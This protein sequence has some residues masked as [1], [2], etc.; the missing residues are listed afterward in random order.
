VG[1]PTLHRLLGWA[2]CLGLLILGACRPAEL[3]PSRAELL[4]A[5]TWLMTGLETDPGF[6]INGVVVSDLFAA[7]PNCDRDD[8]FTYRPDGS[9]RVHE[10]PTKC[11]P[12]LPDKEELGTW[13][14]NADQTVLRTQPQRG[15]PTDYRVLEITP[16]RLKMSYTLSGPNYRYEL[17]VSFAPQS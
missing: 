13:Y 10:G 7:R 11:L 1:N 5:H 6:L 8:G 3:A 17:T 2:A 15:S 9:Y 14:F 16:Q 12:Q 4:T